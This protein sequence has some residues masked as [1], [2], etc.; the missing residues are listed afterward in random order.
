[1]PKIESEKIDYLHRPCSR[2]AP[3]GKTESV[4]T[5][6][7]IKHFDSFSLLKLLFLVRNWHCW[8][9]KAFTH[10][11]TPQIREETA[12]TAVFRQR[13][14][15]WKVV[16]SIAAVRQRPRTPRNWR[17]SFAFIESILWHFNKKQHAEVIFRLSRS[18][19]C[20]NQENGSGKQWSLHAPLKGA[21][22]RYSVIFCAILLWG[23][24]MAAVRF[25][26]RSAS[27]SHDPSWRRSIRCRLFGT[28][29]PDVQW[30]FCGLHAGIDPASPAVVEA[31]VL[32]SL[33]SFL[34]IICI[35][36]PFLSR[37]R[38]E[39]VRWQH[40]SRALT[41][42]VM[43]SG[44]SSLSCLWPLF[45]GHIQELDLTRADLRRGSLGPGH[46]HLHWASVRSV[47]CRPGRGRTRKKNA[48]SLDRTRWW[49]TRTAAQS[50]ARLCNDGCIAG[51]RL[52][53]PFPQAE[54]RDRDAY[55]RIFT[56]PAPRLVWFGA[57]SVGSA[58]CFCRKKSTK[59]H[60]IAWQCTFKVQK[61]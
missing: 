1:M 28:R 44:Q 15:A 47:V 51:L 48:R 49:E 41:S 57:A 25:S 27:R 22:S 30:D 35:P 12:K 13:W 38:Q 23:K 60:W 58:P 4:P 18:V 34:S 10:Q 14:Q 55:A 32:S 52:S 45:G 53:L 3:R 6:S 20:K 17:C 24:I 31:S 33:P 26:I 59:N 21:L 39:S 61:K 37:S 9:R 43:S 46:S 29:W 54:S 56:R 5:H 16:R 42:T 19:L 8:S 40:F 11:M 7:V 2:P 50:W 36:Y